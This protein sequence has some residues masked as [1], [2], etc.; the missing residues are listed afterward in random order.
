MSYLHKRAQSPKLPGRNLHHCVSHSRVKG[1]GGG[2]SVRLD[3]G[4]PDTLEYYSL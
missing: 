4:Y 3:L 2:G 1:G